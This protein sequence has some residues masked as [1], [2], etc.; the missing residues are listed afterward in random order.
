MTSTSPSTRVERTSPTPRDHPRWPSAPPPP[1][2]SAAPLSGCD[3]QQTR[4]Q[5]VGQGC[6]RPCDP[7]ATGGSD[8]SRWLS[9][10]GEVEAAG[11]GPR[12]GVHAADGW[13]RRCS[14]WSGGVGAHRLPLPGAGV[15]IGQL[16][17]AGAAAQARDGRSPVRQE[18][19]REAPPRAAGADVAS[20]ASSCSPTTSPSA[21][22]TCSTVFA[23]Y[24]GV[25]R[26]RR[27]VRRGAATCSTSNIV[28]GDALDMTTR[29][30]SRSRSRSP[31]GAT[32]ARAGSSAATSGSTRSRRCRPSARRHALRRPR[33]ARDL[34]PDA[35]PRL[36]RR[37]T[38]AGDRRDELSRPRSPARPQPRRADVHRQPV[39]RRG[40]HAAGVR[41]PDAR[42]RRR[43]VGD[44]QRRREHLG[45]TRRCGS[46]TRSP[47]PACSCARSPR[48]SSTGWRTRSPTWRSASTTS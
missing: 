23:D 1:A 39:E 48:G 3:R 11:G 7:S 12:R 42:H 47:S 33:Q 28:H 8:R 43:G 27:V 21:A 10:P 30:A 44:A 31:S 41:Q 24:L 29:D 35:R 36:L 2:S 46:S 6:C 26:R 32:S 14:T 38:V 5:P 18:R 34:H 16:P 45:R 17:R 4:R 37:L 22:R 15:R 20:T 40:V 13:S 25:E 9:G 19:L